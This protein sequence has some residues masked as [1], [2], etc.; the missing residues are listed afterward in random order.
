MKN[1]TDKS[2]ARTVIMVSLDGGK[3]EK[4]GGGL[5]LKEEGMF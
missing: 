1:K 4:G 3:E 2:M 5:K